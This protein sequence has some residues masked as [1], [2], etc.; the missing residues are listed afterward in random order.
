MRSFQT[1]NNGKSISRNIQEHPSDELS[2]G[3]PIYR[4]IGNAQL[5]HPGAVNSDKEF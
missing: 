4:I 2:T 3:K 5:I 1:I